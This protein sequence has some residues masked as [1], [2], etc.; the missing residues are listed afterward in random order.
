M[1]SKLYKG[2]R[3]ARYEV[4]D[5]IKSK[6][7]GS[8]PVAAE[9]AVLA[10]ILDRMMLSGQ[11]GALVNSAASEVTCLRMYS[12]WKAYENV[13]VLNDWQRPRNQQG[14]KWRS[15][16]NW[17]LAQEYFQVEDPD[18]PQDLAA[19]DDVSEKLKRKAL[20]NKHMAGLEQKGD[21]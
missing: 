2:G 11:N 14:G 15:K 9:M 5:W 3:I 4:A 16:V 19:D 12:I 7:L 13:H 21:E 8:S 10:Q 1:L 17:N 20:M 18:A 6:E